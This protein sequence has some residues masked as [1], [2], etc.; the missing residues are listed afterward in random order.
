M[1]L[2]PKLESYSLT[3]VSGNG[4]DFDISLFERLI[5]SGFDSAML[6]V[7]HRMKPCIADLIRRQTYPSLQDH[8]SV[9]SYPD[10]R[11]VPDNLL[12]IYHANF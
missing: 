3:K 8:P 7:Q 2:R 4:F 10:V 5:H 1:Q 9:A 11:G 6:G 12:F